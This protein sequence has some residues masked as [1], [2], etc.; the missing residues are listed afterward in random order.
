M[1]KG[2]GLK[3]RR[4]L[5]ERARERVKAGGP[6]AK[7]RPSE[8]LEG[9]RQLKRDL[10]RLARGSCEACGALVGPFDPEHAIDRGDGGADTLDNV[11]LACRYTCHAMKSAPYAKGRLKVIPRGDGSFT[12]ELWKGESKWN[13]T[14]LRRWESRPRAV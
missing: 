10:F 1:P 3:R 13:S 6:L 8:T 7:G 4:R 5:G 2:N 9:W 14:C 12:F 11:W